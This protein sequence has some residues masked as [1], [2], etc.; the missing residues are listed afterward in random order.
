MIIASIF[1]FIYLYVL[2]WIYEE[3]TVSGSVKPSVDI[4]K[5]MFDINDVFYLNLP[6]II[7]LM[8]STVQIPFKWP[9]ISSGIEKKNEMFF[10][11]VNI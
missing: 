11:P 5:W 9:N 7:L 4:S 3:I 6:M 1:H 8:L 10:T 2:F